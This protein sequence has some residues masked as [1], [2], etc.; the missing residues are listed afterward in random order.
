MFWSWCIICGVCLI[1]GLGSRFFWL[2]CLSFF[3]RLV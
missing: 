3:S 1:V 2:N